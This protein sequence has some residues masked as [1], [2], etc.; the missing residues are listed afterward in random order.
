MSSLFRTKMVN[1]NDCTKYETHGAR[2]N[3][4]VDGVLSLENGHLTCDLVLVQLNR[5]QV[6]FSFLKVNSLNHM[7]ML[8]FVLPRKV[9]KQMLLKFNI[10]KENIHWLKYK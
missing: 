6:C 1:V 2:V 5:I 3:S 7:V 8:M 9:R 10:R 4:M